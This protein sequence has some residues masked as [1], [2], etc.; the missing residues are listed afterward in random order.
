MTAGSVPGASRDC[1]VA[2]LIFR[3]EQFVKLCKGLGEA[4]RIE[5]HHRVR[6]ARETRIRC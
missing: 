3:P 4:R 6:C 1:V 5:E 2:W